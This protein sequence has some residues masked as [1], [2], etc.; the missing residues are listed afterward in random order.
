MF[1]PEIVTAASAVLD[2]ARSRNLMIATA[3]SCTGGLIAACLTDI[4]GSSDVVDCGFVTYSNAAKSRMLGVS[5][6]LLEDH[7]AVSAAVAEAMAQG[8]LAQSRAGLSVAVTG[9]AGPGGGSEEK[10]VG[11]VHIAG[12]TRSGDLISERYLMGDIGRDLVRLQTVRA[13]LSVLQRLM[14]P[15]SES[16]G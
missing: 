9:I 2:K 10:P 3:E 14:Q 8:A 5:P 7:G 16:R 12:A 1:S 15:S 11:L 13:A 4:A 6:A